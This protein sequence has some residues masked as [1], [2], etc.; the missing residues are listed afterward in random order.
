MIAAIIVRRTLNLST[1]A[2]ILT[3]ID[4]N[5]SLFAN[6]EILGYYG[7]PWWTRALCRKDGVWHLQ[8]WLE[9]LLGHSH[10]CPTNTN[11]PAFESVETKE[12]LVFQK[13]NTLREFLHMNMSYKEKKHIDWNTI[14][15]LCA[16]LAISGCSI[17]CAVVRLLALISL[18]KAPENMWSL[19][20]IPFVSAVEA[21]VALI[22]SSIPA[23]IPLIVKP[24]YN[25]RTPMTNMK[26]P[27]KDTWPSTAGTLT[28]L[29]G[30]DLIAQEGG[31]SRSDFKPESA[32]AAASETALVIH[33]RINLSE[34]RSGSSQRKPSVVASRKE[35]ETIFWA[36]WMFLLELA[37]DRLKLWL[38]YVGVLA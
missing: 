17:V 24:K 9:C 15:G 28:S 20:V 22:T 26:Y 32:R 4:C 14:V 3:K 6:F 36:A 12:R 27:V 37:Q 8:R 5:S 21:Y 18:T 29:A 7:I 10:L 11:S 2:K 13:S 19:P 34:I 38:E 30:Q 23:F 35:D 31:L 33:D 25:F 16:V 1:T